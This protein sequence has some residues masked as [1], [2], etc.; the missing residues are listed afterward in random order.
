METQ[1]HHPVSQSDEE[2]YH[3]DA[4]ITSNRSSVS[5]IQ[6]TNSRDRVETFQDRPQNDAGY[7][8][9]PDAKGIIKSRPKDSLLQD[10]WLLEIIA[11]IFSILAFA[12]I[13]G[14]LRG[15]EGKPFPNL[16][17]GLTLNTIVSVLATASKSALIFVVAGSI[18]QLK[19]L[20]FRE[21]NRSLSD[22]QT[23]DDASRGPMGSLTILIQHCGWSL[24]S[25]GAYITIL[26]L[27]FD[28]F[29]QQI[30]SY[31]VRQRPS[32]SESA[33]VKQA[34]YF[35]PGL[36]NI[37][38]TNYL[39]AGLWTDDF[40]VPPSCST[41]NC[42]WSTYQSIGLCSACEDLTSVAELRGCDNLNYNETRS[43]TNQINHC[44]LDAG[45]GTSGNIKIQYQSDN[46][47]AFV[48]TDLLYPV[49]FN[50]RTHNATYSGMTHPIA[51]LASA[52]LEL[53]PT[54]NLTELPR[55]IGVKRVQQCAM[56]I[57][58][59]TYNVSVSS[60]NPSIDI[61]SVDHGE[62][63]HVKLPNASTS[64]QDSEAY[65]NCWKPNQSHGSL[66]LTELP[67]GD[68]VDPATFAFCPTN[69]TF[70]L[71]NTLILNEAWF[72]YALGS[73]H[74]DTDSGTWKL[75]SGDAMASDKETFNRIQSAGLEQIMANVA[76]ALT[77]FGLES[78]G[79]PFNGTA[80]VLQTYVEV[81][82][83]WL[84][85]PA[86]LILGGLALFVATAMINRNH[87]LALWKSSILPV[88]YHAANK[89]LVDDSND[90]KTV[91]Q[92]EKNAQSVQAKLDISDDTDR[93]LLRAKAL[94]P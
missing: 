34:H 86:L 72:G 30:L 32:S 60:G 29:V 68:W 28:P 38:Y 13:G 16:A 5:G 1:R 18:G 63:I 65:Y 79:K 78:G 25:L 48:P 20:W 11:L 64:L 23:F 87:K 47:G 80:M 17:H 42:T 46:V 70:E 77:K 91:S 59:K 67:N 55:P 51:V 84:I 94:Y 83:L 81:S 39:Y 82:W 2:E 8:L 22:I 85:L 21:K 74:A 15:Y 45:N 62:M 41:G 66:A 92:M 33:S 40:A 53:Q 24:A 3:D 90:N 76:S 44:Y 6:D 89:D 56:S 37:S 88:I 54:W 49:N 7:N 52:Q 26:A 75:S 27:A 4:N 43:S 57:C 61:T 12:A 14:V 71:M 93:M 10:T 19:W 58:L 73:Y 50:L 9:A 31:P 36:D 69:Y 35:L